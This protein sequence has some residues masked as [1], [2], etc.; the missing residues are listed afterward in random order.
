MAETDQAIAADYDILVSA[1]GV[2][3]VTATALIAMLPELGSRSPKAI[4]ALAGLAP[5][6]RQSGNKT[7]KSQIQGG[8][9]R[10]R[11]AL[12]MAALS[13]SRFCPQLARFYAAVAERSGSRMLALIAVARKLL[14]R[15]K[16]MI[17]ART[18][19]A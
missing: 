12:Y 17:R 7:F 5:F 19:Y 14:I 2:A 18:R 1:P 15:L 13:A 16:A 6:D 10:V 11:R 8:R 3:F 4:A 9:Q